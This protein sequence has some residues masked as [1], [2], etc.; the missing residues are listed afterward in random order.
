MNNTTEILPADNVHPARPNLQLRGYI[1]RT[2][3]PPPDE[4]AA[5]SLHV[6]ADEVP[7]TDFP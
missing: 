1:G 6:A 7:G 5:G 3:E 4:E 2:I